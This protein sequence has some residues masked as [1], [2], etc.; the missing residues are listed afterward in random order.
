MKSSLAFSALTLL[1]CGFVPS[2]VAQEVRPDHDLSRPQSYVLH[3]ASSTSPTGAN[4]DYRVLP[5]GGTLTMLDIDGSAQ[6]SHIWMTISDREKYHLKRI[7][8]RIYWDNETAPSVETPVGDFFGLN[9]GDY[10]NWE[11]AMLS[12]GND[13]GMNSFFPMPFRRHARITLTNE[14]KLPATSVYYNIDYRTGPK[15]ADKDSLYFHAQYHQAVPNKGWTT[16]FYANNDPAINNKTNKDGKDNYVFLEA[17]GRGHYVGMTLGVLQNQDGW[18][19]EGDDMLFIDDPNTPAIVGTGSEDYILGAWDFGGSRFSY[20]SYGAPIKGD[21]LA[22]SRSVV[23]RFHLDSP[24]TFTKYFKGT[25][26]HGHANHRSD[27]YYSESYWY[28]TEPHTPFAPLPPVETRLPAL[29]PT[30]G[31]GNGPQPNIAPP[32]QPLPAPNPGAT[33][34]VAAPAGSTTRTQ[35]STTTPATPQQQTTPQQPKPEPR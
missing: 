14:G 29:M 3:R 27:N 10:H 16:D 20:S 8:L 35:D 19:G 17:N 13:R 15:V 26:E 6:I 9:L 18:W 28:Q 34:S 25:I 1:V 21:E 23:Y 11:S 12:V 33:P 31:P 5:A 32:P 2:A 4:N 22:G 7:V 30:G 24:V